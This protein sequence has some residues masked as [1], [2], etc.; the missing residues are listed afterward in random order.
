MKFLIASDSFKGTLSSE[1]IGKEFEKAFPGSKYIVVS[2][3]GEGFTDAILFNNNAFTAKQF[4]TFDDKKKQISINVAINKDEAIF[5]VASMI[6]LHNYP[7][8]S[9]ISKTTFGIGHIISQLEKDPSITTIGIGL[10]GTSTSDGG[11][12]ASLALGFKYLDENGEEVVSFEE[13]KKAV[14]VVR[15]NIAKKYIGFSDVKNELLGTLGAV[16]TFGT[17][18]FMSDEEKKNQEENMNH[19][20]KLM[21]IS[22]SKLEGAGAAGGLGFFILEHLS[23]KLTSGINE[24][25][26]L[27]NLPELSKDFD[28]LITGEGRFDEQSFM[29][30][31]PVE[32]ANN[33]KT[34]NI[35][36]AGFITASIDKVMN[37]FDYHFELRL[38]DEDINETIKNS[39]ERLASVI[40]R[41]KDEVK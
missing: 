6:A 7:N 32:I 23:G 25:I 28:Y 37:M 21:N 26:R 29:G 22:S 34:K 39:K 17:Q 15:P 33:S 13:I 8:E 19:Y 41:I 4:V 5:D 30:K 16:A 12:G 20:A 24:V 18:K 9:A 31:V 27:S 11:F 40:D 14:S 35:L 1:Y 3:G 2:D 10:G 38:N 36:V